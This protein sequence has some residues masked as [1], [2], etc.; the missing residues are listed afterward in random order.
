MTAA[1]LITELTKFPPESVVALSS[2]GHHYDSVN[3]ERS[4]GGLHVLP[5]V[6]GRVLVAED[7]GGHYRGV[8]AKLRRE[9]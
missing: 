1:E 8:A 6:N 3:H 2:M 7:A 4:H 5:F 9:S